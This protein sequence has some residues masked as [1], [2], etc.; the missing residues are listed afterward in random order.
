MP[1]MPDLFVAILGV[2]VVILGPARLT[3]VIV[4]DSFPPAVRVRIWWDSLTEKGPLKSWNSL[5]HC[6]WCLSFWVTLACIGW[7][8]GAWYVEWLMWA[9]W[10]FWGALAAS[11]VGAIIT[12]RD[13]PGD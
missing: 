4:H 1:V 7:F 13:E 2:A 10:I 5:L 3:R 12:S 9:W 6:W 11:Y 8:I